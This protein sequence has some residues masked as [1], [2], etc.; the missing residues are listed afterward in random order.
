MIVHTG[1]ILDEDW[2]SKVV[3]NKS[4]NNFVFFVCPDTRTLTLIQD[5]R[6]VVA[7]L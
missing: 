4:V 6:G 2:Y 5:G 1:N 7:R 3:N